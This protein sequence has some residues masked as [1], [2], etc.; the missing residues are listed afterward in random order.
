M[1]AVIMSGT[2]LYRALMSASADDGQAKEAAR[3]LEEMKH[4]LTELKVTT[5][6][7]LALMLVGTGISVK[8]LFSL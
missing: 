5:R 1:E 2:S 3:E 4:I 6:I 7:I 8:I